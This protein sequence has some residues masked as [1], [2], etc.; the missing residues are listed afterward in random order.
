M[1][2]WHQ[3]ARLRAAYEWLIAWY[4]HEQ[5]EEARDHIWT[6]IMVH[7]R[8][9]LR[10]SLLMVRLVLSGHHHR[11]RQAVVVVVPDPALHVAGHGPPH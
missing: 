10:P 8:A 6:I 5:A 1:M 9:H 4:Q 3:L 2:P 11:L 7:F